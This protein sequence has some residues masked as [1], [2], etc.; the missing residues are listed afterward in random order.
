MKMYA[1]IDVLITRKFVDEKTKV[2]TYQASFNNTQTA[3][4]E[5]GSL[6]DLPATGKIKLSHPL[7]R[8]RHLMVIRVYVY[9]GT[10]RYEGVEEI[11]DPK[12]IQLLTG[13]K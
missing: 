12:I 6:V 8:G 13:E 11:K 9:Q 3:R 7:P 2:T 1:F 4:D 10:L 5:D